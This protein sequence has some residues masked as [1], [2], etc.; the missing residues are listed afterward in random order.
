MAWLRPG[1]YSY[2]GKSEGTVLN[3]VEDRTMSVARDSNGDGV[4]GADE[5]MRSE[6]AFGYAIQIHA[7]L[8][9]API[10]V[11]CQTL[12]PK[13]FQQLRALIDAAQQKT[14]SYILLRRPNDLTG[15][16]RW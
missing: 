5:S 16:H 4:I 3:P 2:R 13:D 9:G 1:V 11:G 12:P 15:I 6:K 10:S 7:G 8:F 14:F